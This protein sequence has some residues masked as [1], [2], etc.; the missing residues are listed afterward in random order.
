MDFSRTKEQLDFK[1]AVTKFAE[2]ELNEG[3]IERDRA[4]ELLRENRGQWARFGILGLLFP[5]GHKGAGAD[6]LTTILMM[7]G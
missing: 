3:L 1:D 5:E 7:D 6:V 2:N 4:D